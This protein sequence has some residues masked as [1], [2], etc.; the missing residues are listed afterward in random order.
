MANRRKKVCRRCKKKG[1]FR[2]AKQKHCMVCEHQINH[3]ERVSDGTKYS[4]NI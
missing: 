4:W 1:L 3:V 2:N